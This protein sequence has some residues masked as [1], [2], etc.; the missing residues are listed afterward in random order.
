MSSVAPRLFDA[1]QDGVTNPSHSA[2]SIGLNKKQIDA[3]LYQLCYGWSEKCN[4]F[5]YDDVCD[6][7]RPQWLSPES[8]RFSA[9]HLIGSSCNRQKA[10]EI[11]HNLSS[12]NNRSFNKLVSGAILHKLHLV[13]PMI[14][15]WLYTLL[16]CI[17][18]QT[19]IGKLSAPKF[20]CTN[21]EYMRP[22]VSKELFLSESEKLPLWHSVV[23]HN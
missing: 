15:R 8:T 6:V 4:W 16:L 10:N 18:S 5:K 9:E 21:T 12:C 3:I 17:H 20:M 22:R 23:A 11:F 13:Q 7:C 19:D 1:V 2:D 14:D